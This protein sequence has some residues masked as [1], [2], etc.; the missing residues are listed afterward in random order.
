MV[1]PRIIAGAS[2]TL[3]T[4]SPD[5]H[6]HLETVREGKRGVCSPPTFPAGAQLLLDCQ[7]EIFF[8]AVLSLKKNTDQTIQSSQVHTVTL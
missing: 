7:K 3:F 6:L 4:N 5:P 8:R 2:E 1:D